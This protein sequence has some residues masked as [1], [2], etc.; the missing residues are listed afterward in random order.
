MDSTNNRRLET[1]IYAGLWTLAV[2]L[3]LLDIIRARSYTELPLIDGESLIKLA[4]KL[5]P[6]LALFVLNNYLLIPR[7]LKRGFYVSFLFAVVLSVAVVWLWQRFQFYGFI[8]TEGAHEFERPPHP[9]PQPLIP[10][11]LFLD[12]IYDLLI[13]GVNIAISLIFQHFQDRLEQGVLMKKNAENQLTYLK[14]QV[15]PHFYMNMLNNIHG[16]IEI[17]PAKAQD[18]VIEMSRLMRYMLYESSRPMIELTAE[19]GFI[20]DYLGL[21]RERYHED[22]VSISADLPDSSVTAG[23]K[24]PPLLFI[25]FIENA[26]KHGVSYS[27]DSYVSINLR[28]DDGKVVFNCLNSIHAATSDSNKEHREGIGLENVKQR[29]DIIFGD[30]YSLDI[31]SGPVTYTVN[32]TL[33]YENVDN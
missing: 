16:M 17:N 30:R 25:V 15:N 11:P 3:F 22:A 12:V 19:V 2:L 21:M 4:A 24:V 28:V 26:F 18:M 27:G 23:I 33:P 5:L 14:A 13:V 32:L 10:L 6:F 7:L 9:G 1:I 8:A 20:R 29:M 31:T